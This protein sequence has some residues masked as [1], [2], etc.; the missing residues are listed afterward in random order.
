MNSI[1]SFEIT[2][3]INKLELFKKKEMKESLKLRYLMVISLL[4]GLLIKPK[5]D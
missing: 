1:K 5:E 2:E 3:M 4:N